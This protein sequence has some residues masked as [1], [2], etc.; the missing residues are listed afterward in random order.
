MSLPV[1]KLD[2]RSFKDLADEARALIPRYSKEWTNFNPSDPG[3][4]LLELFAWLSEMTIFRIDQIPQEHILRYL[5]LV[6][7]EKDEEE[8]LP[9]AIARA[10][11]RVSRQF[12]LVNDGDYETLVLEK[13]REIHP[14]LVGK[15][16]CVVDRNLE[17][18]NN[19]AEKPGHTS[20]IVI[21][22]SLVDDYCTI[23]GRP[24]KAL[25]AL[26]K[27]AL[28]ETRV[29]TH[30]LH[31]VGPRF[32]T[33]KINVELVPEIG[34]DWKQVRKDAVS[35]LDGFCHPFSGGPDGK[36]W[37]LGR[38]LYRSEI[39]ELMEGIPD[40]DYTKSILLDGSVTRKYVEVGEFEFIEVIPEI[41]EGVR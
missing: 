8:S 2:D 20:I 23:E 26:L 31:F 37:P 6:G 14:D 30:R 5:N 3:I 36:G 17:L 28:N 10:V 15:V 33:V 34:A 16:V 22:G 12:R 25:L 19:T 27:D 9:S 7:I 24:R 35:R 21:P 1:P 41:R 38:F 32:K 29:L 11:D 13:M 4:T 18:H 39:Y 40:V